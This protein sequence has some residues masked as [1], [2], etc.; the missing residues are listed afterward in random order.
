[1]FIIFFFILSKCEIQLVLCRVYYD[2]QIPLDDSYI[3]INP[4]ERPMLSEILYLFKS[5][6]K[7]EISCNHV[8]DDANA[9]C[10]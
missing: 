1:M 4:F 5:F 2:P 3:L 7:N 8:N 9:L 10:I 6:N